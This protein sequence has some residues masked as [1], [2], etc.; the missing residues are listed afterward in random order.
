[1]DEPSIFKD[2]LGGVLSTILTVSLFIAGIM[3]TRSA[4]RQEIQESAHKELENRVRILEKDTV[5]HD[6][7]RRLENKIDE[8]YKQITDRLDRILERQLQ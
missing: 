2:L 8:H 3:F 7:L 1:M 5:T 6:D 4:K